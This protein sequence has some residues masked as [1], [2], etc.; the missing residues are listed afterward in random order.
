MLKFNNIL[1]TL[2]TL[3]CSISYAFCADL[4]KA[5]NDFNNNNYNAAIPIFEELCTREHNK[6]ACIGLALAYRDGKGKS[7]NL[8]KAIELFDA[9]LNEDIYAQWFLAQLYEYDLGD[10]D[11]LN[12]AY[13]LY[14]NIGKTGDKN[15]EQNV[16]SAFERLPVYKFLVEF[17]DH[18]SDLH[19][20]RISYE[21]FCNLTNN[22]N[23]SELPPEISSAFL[24][25]LPMIQ[26]TNIDFLNGFIGGFIN[27]FKAA[28]DTYDAVRGVKGRDYD[29]LQDKFISSLKKYK[30]SSKFWNQ[31]LQR[32]K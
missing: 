19:K 21:T 8:N 15:F 25:L 3:H 13:S 17:Y 2:I 18:L 24:A 27:P 11:S 30:I 20:D 1:I 14:E 10:I 12:K 7:V 26:E 23:L 16:N 29:M 5:W 4:N 28:K 31:Q 22:M 9:F 32:S 6:D